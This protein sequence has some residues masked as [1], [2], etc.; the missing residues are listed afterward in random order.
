MAKLLVITP[1]LIKE[2]SIGFFIVLFAVI[3]TCPIFYDAT[4]DF[5]KTI[6]IMSVCFLFFLFFVS[7]LTCTI[8][9]SSY[10]GKMDYYERNY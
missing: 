6:K 4:N 2:F 1:G 3:V 9:R 5:D 7:L 8:A 10:E